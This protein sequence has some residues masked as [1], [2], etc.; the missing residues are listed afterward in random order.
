MLAVSFSSQKI[1]R[2]R[3]RDLENA[4]VLKAI[5]IGFSCIKDRS[6]FKLVKKINNETEVYIFP[7]IDVEKLSINI[8]PVIGFNNIFL[9][10]ALK[11][12]KVFIP[13]HVGYRIL[14][15]LIDENV[16]KS[17][18]DSEFRNSKELICN[19][20]EIIMC[21]AMNDIM[22]FID[23]RSVKELLLRNVQGEKVTNLV[24]LFE[25]E[26]LEALGVIFEN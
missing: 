5:E 15:H 4:V 12:A 10:N 2:K 18:Q 24:T 21:D 3:A 6:H 14:G 7:G 1:L 19:I 20:F 17:F 13:Y 25:R 11:A 22:R 8:N 16:I 23:I 26:K 9:T